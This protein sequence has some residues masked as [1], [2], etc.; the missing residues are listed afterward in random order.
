MEEKDSKKITKNEKIENFNEEE[1]IIYKYLIGENN[2]NIKSD[3]EK[4]I[5][6]LKILNESIPKIDEND[7]NL[8]NNLINQ[9]FK[10]K[11][12]KNKN[13]DLEDKNENKNII[14]TLDNLLNEKELI[15]KRIKDK[16]ESIE[17]LKEINK[18]IFSKKINPN[19][20]K[21]INSNNYLCRNQELK[22]Y[23][24]QLTKNKKFEE[25]EDLTEEQKIICSFRN[26]IK[27]S[28]QEA[29]NNITE[30]KTILKL[31]QEL[32]FENIDI[33]G[34]INE[35]EG[36]DNTN[37]NICKD[38]KIMEFF[39]EISITPS[40]DI[41]IKELHKYNPF[42]H[43]E[44]NN[45][46]IFYKIINLLIN[47]YESYYSN[48]EG[49]NNKKPILILL[50]NNLEFF[51]YLINYYLIFYNN[52][53]IKNN[54]L[55]KTINNSL[56][57]IVIKIKN[58]SISIFSQV[59]ADFNKDLIEEIEQIETFENV[60][61]EN[62]FDFC[63]KK[64]Q[65][66]VKMIF[67]FFDELRITAIHREVIYY[68]NN[69]LTIY[70]NSLNEKI[71]KVRNYDLKDIQA[72]LN[73]SQEIF[74]IMKKNIE[75]IS[76]QNMDLSVKFMN[77][78]EQN[79]GYLKFQEILFVL[80]SNLKQIKNYLINANYSIYIRKDDLIGLLDSTFDPS[81]KLTELKKLINENIKEKK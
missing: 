36:S 81:E 12:N 67:S 33:Q 72:L 61:K 60:Y 76:S 78:L 50:H 8:A 58:I 22:N 35:N 64:V 30:E 11:E 70:F 21:K 31:F 19:I 4:K 10:E 52:N 14:Y 24:T 40:F 73:L 43:N 65:K 45:T 17:L 5:S 80:N 20:I 53:E 79:L 63:L 34:I 38:E 3:L 44:K 75:K 62:L 42:N 71:L 15:E 2:Q 66:T 37:S 74:K 7:Q 9:Y 32:N 27:N 57:N 39:S 51:T 16:K 48:I 1:L 18:S 54:E 68:F 28:Y 23:I 59:M 25:K 46:Y 26:I 6:E 55:A 56:I 69:I 29:N 13:K 47:R 41:F 77:I 49:N